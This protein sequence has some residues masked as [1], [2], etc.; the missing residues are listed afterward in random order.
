MTRASWILCG[1]ALAFLSWLFGLATCLAES[2]SCTWLQRHASLLY[3]AITAL[4]LVAFYALHKLPF[5]NRDRAAWRTQTLLALLVFPWFLGHFWSGPSLFGAINRGRQ[6]WTMAAMRDIS[7]GIELY[8]SQQG[9]YPTANNAEELRREL[10]GLQAIPLRDAWG[11]PWQV[12]ATG[13]GYT[14]VSY[15]KCGEADLPG[16]GAYAPGC[17]ASFDADIVLVNGHFV[18]W[19]EGVQSD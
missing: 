5:L 2:D 16:G 7:E 9:G 19:P 3:L 6:K 11:E 14:I 12:S 10:S 1:G 8:R 17:T 15:G 4:T 18:C 13:S